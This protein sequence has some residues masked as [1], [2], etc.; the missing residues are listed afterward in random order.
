MEK[1]KFII[2]YSKEFEV[3]RVLSTKKRFGWYSN[4]GYN[5]NNFILP[6]NLSAEELSKKSEAEIIFCVN[7]EYDAEFFQ[8][9]IQTV[10]SLLPNYL[11]KLADYLSE[12][13][14][15]VLPNI[16]IKF[17]RYGIGGSYNIPNTVIV[18]TS[19]LFNVG[20]VRVILHEII[21]LHIQNLID[22]Y[23]IGQWEKEIIV[24]SL[25]EKFS[26]DIF[27]RQNYQIDASEIQ[28]IF[29]ENYPKIELII[30]NVSKIKK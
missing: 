9:H 7:E 24:D 23:K 4:N 11:D 20:L 25:F 16:E 14:I 18:N 17:T 2:K 1:I 12:I 3:Q 10:N 27:K 6:K 5:L 15:E 30:R 13:D 29:K 28:K 21:H 8:P 22:K 19:K 26:V